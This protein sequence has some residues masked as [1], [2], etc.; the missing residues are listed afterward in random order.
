[1][2]QFT[3]LKFS[4]PADV[5]STL[6][7]GTLRRPTA[8]SALSHIPHLSSTYHELGIVLGSENEETKGSSFLSFLR[9]IIV[10][11]SK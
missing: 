10:L 9:R 8:D 5:N 4:L 11:N 2:G 6:V 1:M 7:W 3:D